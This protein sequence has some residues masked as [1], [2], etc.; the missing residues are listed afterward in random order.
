M[1][2]TIAKKTQTNCENRSLQGPE[3]TL[4]NPSSKDVETNSLDVTL[5]RDNTPNGSLNLPRK[6]SGGAIRRGSS[7]SIFLN[8]LEGCPAKTA[9]R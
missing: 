9:S 1:F 6:D 5:T 8:F 4:E 2:K 7:R 3:V